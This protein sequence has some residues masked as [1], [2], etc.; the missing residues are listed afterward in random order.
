MLQNETER[1]DMN[2]TPSFQEFLLSQTKASMERDIRTAVTLGDH[3]RVMKL[4][5]DMGALDRYKEPAKAAP[6]VTPP[7]AGSYTP[8]DVRAVMEKSAPWFGTDVKKTE[9]AFKAG[10]LLDK[11]KLK[12]PDDYAKAVIAYVEKE[13]GGAPADDD[14]DTVT[15]ADDDGAPADDDDADEPARRRKVPL[16]P[17]G[18]DSRRVTTR[19]NAIPTKFSQV[20]NTNNERSILERMARKNNIK[21]VDAVKSWYEVEQ[22]KKARAKKR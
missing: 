20:P 7:A 22:A 19:P 18:G 17:G 9:L 2:D 4:T 21:E 14:D 16:S 8:E 6:V 3:D 5:S 15:L 10:N 13:L 11:N 1:S 12:T